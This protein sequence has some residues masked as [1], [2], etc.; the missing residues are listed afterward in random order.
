MLKLLKIPIGFFICG[1]C[2]ALFSDPLITFLTQHLD[3]EHQDLYRSL[4]DFI[5]VLLGTFVLYFEIKKQEIKL[6]KSEA[7]YR[8]LFES[9]PNPMWIYNRKNLH[10]VNVN[11]A[12]IEKYGYSK[13]KFLKM[14]INDIRP[15]YDH[16]KLNKYLDEI[17]DKE[18]KTTGV[19]KHIKESGE[20]I[21][22]AIVSHDILFNNQRCRLVMATEIT[23]LVVKE[24][25]LN[26]AYGKIKAQNTTL[27]QLAW[28]NSHELRRPLCSVL[29]LINLLKESPNEQEQKEYINLLEECSKE[30][31]LL[32]KSNNNEVDNI[33]TNGLF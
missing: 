28:S 2:W 14:T 8:K 11:G 3:P 15:V 24:K 4:N 26:D 16:D 31:D 27:L 32:L 6:T 10:F 33:Q 29:S 23:E 12:A 17:N 5:F 21:D 20:I 18:T 30:L 22:V 9:N 7:D 13:S 1:I 19:W 25:R